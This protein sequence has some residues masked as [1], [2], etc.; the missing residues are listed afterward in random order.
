MAAVGAWPVFWTPSGRRG[1]VAGLLGFVCLPWGRGRSPG[2]WMAAVGVWSVPRPRMDAVG[3][4]TLPWAPYGR[5]G[6]VAGLLGSVWSPWGR[7]R[8]PWPCQ[9]VVGVWPV[10]WALSGCRGA[11][12]VPWVMYGCSGGVAGPL[13]QVWTPWGVAGPLGPIWPPWGRGRSPGP[14]MAAVRAWLVPWALY[15]RRGV[16]AG[17]LGPVWPPWVYPFG[18]KC[19]ARCPHPGR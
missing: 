12:P 8:S 2:P 13:G 6:G 4:W 15:G 17:S 7:G 11:W 1:G 14:C 5:P 9:V 19:Y 3:V 16:V 10:P 18:S